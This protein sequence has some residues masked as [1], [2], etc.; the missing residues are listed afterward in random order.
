[1]IVQGIILGL[2]LSFMVGPLF[3]TIL[4]A[5]IGSGFRA[6]MAV[7]VGI[8][9]SDFSY[10]VG[11]MFALDALQVVSDIPG[12]RLWAGVVGG[13]VLCLFGITALLRHAPKSGGIKGVSIPVS[14]FSWFLRGFF[15]NTI[16]PFTVFFWIGVASAVVIPNGWT[17]LETTYFFSGMF[18]TL[19]ITDTLKAYLAKKISRFMTPNHI[20]QFQRGIGF[21]LLI[22][23]IVLMFRVMA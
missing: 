16:N 3:F 4:Q 2:T 18:G 5:G 6:G 23:G 10:V 11:I 12:F 8:W 17:N 14:N 15:I 7:A 9:L 20:R 13:I 19:V 21:L 1:M 22:F